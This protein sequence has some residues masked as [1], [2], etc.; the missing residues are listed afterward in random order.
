MNA[1]QKKKTSYDSI[2]IVTAVLKT[3]NPP[4]NHM[5]KMLEKDTFFSVF[6]RL[7]IFEYNGKIRLYAA[8]GKM[9]AFLYGTC[10]SEKMHENSIKPKRYKSFV[11]DGTISDL[12]SGHRFISRF[13]LF[14]MIVN[15][16]K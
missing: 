13:L 11:N 16:T 8:T 10:L 6:I 3:S 15:S 12:C 5:Y 1:T 14:S 7:G 4:N 2:S 9:M